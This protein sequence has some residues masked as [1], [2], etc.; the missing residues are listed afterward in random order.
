MKKYIHKLFMSGFLGLMLLLG[1]CSDFLTRPPITE[2]TDPAFWSSEANARSYAWGLY[3][4]FYGY[5]NASGTTAEFYWQSAGTD[6][7]MMYSDNLLQNTFSTLPTAASNTNS[8]WND[9]YTWVRRANLMIER[10]PIIPGI[11]NE[12][13]NH[14]MGIARFFRANSYYNLVAYFGD[15][16]YIDSYVDPKDSDN[17]WGQRTDRATVIANVIADLEFAANN[18]YANDGRDAIN[19]YSAYALLARV[20]LF[21][22]TFK[23][24]HGG[25]G[26]T[27]LLQKAKS[28]AEAIM[29]S[30]VYAVNN[31]TVQG[32]DYYKA[33]YNSLSL[34]TNTEMILY[35][36][37]ELG[38]L[39]HALQAYT[40]TSTTVNGITKAAVESFVCT[41]GLPINQSQLYQ[42][43]ANFTKVM[44]NRD[45]RLYAVVDQDGLGYNENP[46]HGQMIATTGYVTNLWD[47]SAQARNINDVINIGSNHIDAPIF[48]YSEILLVY[49]E[50]C[51]ELGNIT[52][53]DLNKSINLLRTRAG[54]AS[55]TVSGT[56]ASANGVLINDTK[57]TATL[58]TQSGGAVSSILWEIRRERRAEL[59]GWVY[60]RNQ[61]LIRWKKGDYL[62][63]QKNP[64]CKLGAYLGTTNVAGLIL[65]NGYIDRYP[66]STRTFAERY[67]L[68]PIPTSEI[69][70]YKD[71]GVTLTQNPGW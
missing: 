10:V 31:G 54:I 43:D 32:T 57:R 39:A 64:D 8:W 68:N 19:K 41:D 15:V 51:A 45:K 9:H 47:N 60:L 48:T 50:A 24:Y 20:C 17:V 71:A 23:K 63:T 67:Y 65:T 52:N 11:T 70:T 12:V 58:E 16:P 13:R 49:A 53:A 3:N 36:R 5:G 55:L 37:Y 14:L 29:N 35:K 26:S 27:E 30:N 22:G 6:T 66:T 7:R 38:V 33:K 34:Q 61:D 18:L 25:T 44:A 42:G 21:E 56:N 46:I 28:A 40:H 2:F 1:S 69:N 59:M 62:D 4:C